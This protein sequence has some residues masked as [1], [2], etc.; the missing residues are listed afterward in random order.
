MAKKKVK[1]VFTAGDTVDFTMLIGSKASL[2]LPPNDPC[3]FQLGT[4]I[5]EVM[6]D[7]SDGYRSS[8]QE[9]SIV[10]TGCNTPANKLLAEVMI[11]Q[12]PAPDCDIY[13]LTDLKDGHIWLR[14]G[15]DHTDNY[16]PSFVY[17]W[18]PKIDNGY[19]DLQSK[20]K[21]V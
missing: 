3:R 7:E 19:K 21:S 16:Y 11:K 5:F 17:N 4:I 1:Q 6:E 2:Y 14:F 15:T 8:M 20:I 10:L 13:C 9:V 18:D 12:D